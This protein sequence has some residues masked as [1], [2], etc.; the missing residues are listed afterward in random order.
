MSFTNLGI[1][2]GLPLNTLVDGL[3]Q[4]EA[5]PTETRLNAQQETIELE[6]SGVGAFRSALSSFQSTVDKLAADNAFNQQSIT[7]SNNN[8]SVTTNGFASNGEFDVNVQQLATGTQLKSGAI[9]SSSTTLGAGTLS[10][11]AGGNSFDVAID[12][13]D[14]LSAIR[15]KIN[16]NANNFGVT[17]NIINADAGTFLILNSTETGTANSLTV[18][19]SDPSLSAISTNNTVERAAQDAVITIDGNT[20][21][22]GTNEFKNIIEDVTITA[23]SVTS[24]DN[25]IISI[26]QDTE[27]GRELLD[28]FVSSYNALADQLTGL[29]APRQGR[30]AFDPNVRQVR[31]QL[32]DVLL[33]TV[34]NSSIGNLQNLG[35]ELNSDG[36]L[37]VS[38]FSSENIQTGEQR[39]SGALSDSLEE[40]GKL[41]ASD[42]G[43]ATRISS[44]LDTYIDSDGVLSQ[45]Q[46]SLNAQLS[47]LSDQ[48]AAFAERL[49]DYEARLIAQFTALDSAVAG[50]NSTRDFVTN[51][52]SANFN[53]GD[54]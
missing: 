40:V 2:S 7:T 12:A 19:S 43:V 47:D 14:D 53:N 32:T 41:F 45:R 17:A 11:N 5:L 22:N 20:I 36:K 35:I 50:F 39:I 42:D 44:V 46:T 27:S 18:T 3:L 15:D 31:Q 38:R 25:S 48:R 23:N 28:E 4:A 9:A 24:T 29:G 6:L 8:I 26:S 37:E 51:T 10:F 21:T 34:S 16:A 33:D 52:L 30:L 13:A 49:A 54:N 1:G